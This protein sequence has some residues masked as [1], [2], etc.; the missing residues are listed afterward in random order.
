MENRTTSFPNEI[1]SFF[2][3]PSGRSLM[4]KGSP[5]T[6]KTTFALQL[7]EEMADPDKSFYLST[8]VSDEALYSQFPWLEEK[9]MRS[10]IVD[11]GRIFLKT[12]YT[13]EGGGMEEIVEASP[14]KPTLSSAKDFL[15]SIGDEKGPPTKVDRTRLSA[16]MEKTRMPEIESTYDRVEYVLP[17]KTT[18]VIDSV[19]G[20]THKYNI[21]AEELITVLQKDLVENSNA[22]LILVLEK[23]QIPQLEY[24][25]DGV[26]SLSMGK[27]DGRRMR[28]VQLIKLR[29]TEIR[30]PSYLLTLQ[31]GRF[32]CF[33]PFSPD[34]SRTNGWEVKPD[35]ASHYSTGISD[36]DTLLEGGFR[37]GSYNVL[38]IGHKVSNEE[39]H[40]IVIPILL[41][42]IRQ[43]RG[44]V[45]VLTGGDHAET[46]RAELI[47][48]MQNE[49]FDNQVRIAD[50]FIAS[51][52]K[53]YIMALGTRNKEEALKTW[54]ENLA[55]LRGSENKPILDYTGFDTLEY[56]RG[57]TIA[58]KDLL[59]A[60]AKTK[61]SQDL[62]LGIIKP[63]LKLT[64]EIMNMADTYLKIVDINKSPC[65]YGVKPKTMI[66][67]IVTDEK[68]GYPHVR[69][70]P[71]V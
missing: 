2:N 33:E 22:D 65:I 23:A 24:L 9:E 40:S 50:Y 36:L 12:L 48:F 63:G 16:L 30:Q 28:E 34:R 57:D 70:V 62:G 11:S 7:L 37:K 18:L 4:I 42:F 56:L 26:I 58:I 61:I 13:T 69:L 25:V 44:V 3:R 27:L 55:A 54:K 20:V 29:A 38:E 32:M 64:Q 5:G 31:N 43:D 51:S 52:D 10:R 21:E 67:A 60:V 66:Y 15:K 49:N 45:A 19:E 8:R 59:N 17:Q 6:G 39:Y 68:K 1:V 71:I 53:P 14:E 41:N 35:T 46:T 47:P